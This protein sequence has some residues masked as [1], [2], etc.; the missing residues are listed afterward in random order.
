MPTIK[1]AFD[2]NTYDRYIRAT[3]YTGALNYLT[4]LYDNSDDLEERDV[5]KPFISNL[6]QKIHRDKSL[7][8]NAES[9][10]Q[11]D[12]YYFL[13]AINNKT[14]I[15]GNKYYDQFSKELAS[16]GSNY[17]EERDFLGRIKKRKIN[18]TAASLSFIFPHKNVYDT[19]LSNLGITEKELINLGIELGD[20]NGNPAIKINKSNNNFYDVVNNIYKAQQQERNKVVRAISRFSG[21]NLTGAG[22]IGSTVNSAGDVVYRGYDASGKP[23]KEYYTSLVDGKFNRIFFEINRIMDGAKDNY[24]VLEQK[25]NRNLIVSS[26]RL[27]WKTA[28][29]ARAEE[30]LNST[31]NTE[32][33]DKTIKRLDAQLENALYGLILSQE[34]VYA[35]KDSDDPNYHKLDLEESHAYQ[36]IIRDAL[37]EKRLN[38]SMAMYGDKLGY[39]ID[40]APK[41]DSK[42]GFYKLLENSFI[43]RTL[44]IENPWPD[45]D[46]TKAFEQRTEFRAMKE[47]VLMGMYNYPY[48]FDDG[49]SLK[50]INENTGVYT[51]NDGTKRGVS[52]N[53]A[54]SILDEQFIKEDGINIFSKKY[55]DKNNPVS[56]KLN[57]FE[58]D[59]DKDIWKFAMAAARELVPDVQSNEYA[60]KTYD[61]YQSI[62]SGIRYKGTPGITKDN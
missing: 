5:I 10:D 38:I 6:R 4:S 28:S 12:K 16:L 37:R 31:G 49:S 44:F 58:D 48:D 33:Y 51:S 29:H 36:Q 14:S 7:L 3:D 53:E 8:S 15:T 2:K 57:T 43:H 62:L 32:E 35:T 27:P 56:L 42:G 18:K 40:I 41:S 46:E 30:L 19:F 54:L 61:L 21:S 17:T 11:K 1:D 25:R 55:K 45:E 22:T 24:K 23:L 34:N 50:L 60:E 52:R 9:Q 39:Q 59:I 26:F 47:L 13:D 20:N